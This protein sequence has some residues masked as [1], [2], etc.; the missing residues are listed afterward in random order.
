MPTCPYCHIVSSTRR[1]HVLHLEQNHES[2]H[3]NCIA[4][5]RTQP[6][7]VT[8][9]NPPVGVD[10]VIG[11]TPIE[12]LSTPQECVP[13]V[14]WVV[15][16]TVCISYE[17][18]WVQAPQSMELHRRCAQCANN[19]YNDYRCTEECTNAGNTV[20]YCR[21]GVCWYPHP[22]V[23]CDDRIF[24]WGCRG[25]VGNV[26]CEGHIPILCPVPDEWL[27]AHFS[28]ASIPPSFSTRLPPP[29]ISTVEPVISC[30]AIQSIR[31][32]ID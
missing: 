18:K 17:S 1:Q 16:C 5:S 21:G 28:Q 30:G 25:R 9:G 4:R 32:K 7:S 6:V 31:P 13:I 23:G 29:R 14:P 26:Y 3:K 8:S 12:H 20:L 15:Y 22:N 11:S 27:Q 24:D 10:T 2:L 19:R